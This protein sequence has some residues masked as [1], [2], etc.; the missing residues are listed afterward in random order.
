MN[1]IEQVFGVPRVLLPVI[2]PVSRATALE[3]IRVA[4]AEGARGVFLIDQGMEE[5]G[6]LSLVRAARDTFPAL[7][8][9]V[10]LL[11][12]SPAE[13]LRVALDACDGRIDGIWSDDARIDERATSQSAA[14]EFVV[15]RCALRWPGLYFGGVAFKYQRKIDA[16]DLGRATELASSRMD[17]V[18]TSGPGTG[19]AAS[20]E[21]VRTMSLYAGGTA[22]ALASGVTAENA[23]DYMHLAHAFLVG[24]G[25]EALL[26]V[27]DGTKVRALI[28]ALDEAP[29]SD[30]LEAS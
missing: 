27:V 8:V 24:T 14:E 19:L 3:S 16:S 25:I 28:R 30:R 26:G 23:R 21:K 17:V 9:G 2:H 5:D 29:H 11:A 15:T 22:L 6:V 1:R 12:R 20:T 4:H 7:W 10:N 13:A 18:C